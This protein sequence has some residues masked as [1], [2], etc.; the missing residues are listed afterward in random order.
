MSTYPWRWWQWLPTSP[1]SAFLRETRFLKRLLP[2]NEN[3]AF[4]VL[5]TLM[6]KCFNS[7]CSGGKSNDIKWSNLPISSTTLAT[8][9]DASAAQCVVYTAPLLNSLWM[10]PCGKKTVRANKSFVN[11]TLLSSEFTQCFKITASFGKSFVGFSSGYLPSLTDGWCPQVNTHK[12]ELFCEWAT[13]TEL[14]TSK[15]FF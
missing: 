4:Q 2:S 14:R 7:F 11:Q 10:A 1:S 6:G 15:T 13:Y 5:L 9:E 8:N 3:L 12:R